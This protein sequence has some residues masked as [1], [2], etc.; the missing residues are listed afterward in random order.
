MRTLIQPK[1]LLWVAFLLPSLGKAQTAPNYLF[2]GFSNGSVKMKS[3]AVENAPLNY[4]VDDQT[5]TFKQNGK[6]LTLTNVSD[7]DTVYIQDKKF[8]PAQ[9]KFYEVLTNSK[10]SLLVQYTGKL[11]P[12]EATSDKDN[13]SKRDANMVSNTVSGAY[14]NRVYKGN[15]SL[16]VLTHYWLRRGNSFYKADTEK[17]IV[18]VFPD[19][20]AAISTFI[21]ANHLDLSKSSDLVKLIN[22]C[23]E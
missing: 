21:K 18:K 4:N 17:Q 10:I 6:A 12:M 2:N 7:V 23:N 22:F 9:D 19:K 3:G 8:I 15:Y 5:I 13:T 16:E 20:S 14:V 11:R 1:Q